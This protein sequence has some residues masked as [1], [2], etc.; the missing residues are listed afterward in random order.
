MTI[1]RTEE[2]PGALSGGAGAVMESSTPTA[3]SPAPPEQ[4]ILL[5]QDECLHECVIRHELNK[6]DGSL[7]AWWQC[8]DCEL[9][10][11]PEWI[12]ST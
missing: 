1:R 4:T 12:L 2:V 9:K 10:F 11:F 3:L 7:E 5:P 8:W 6:I